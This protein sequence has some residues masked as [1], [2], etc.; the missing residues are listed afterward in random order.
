MIWQKN[1]KGLN[2]I[3]SYIKILWIYLARLYVIQF[4]LSLFHECFSPKKAYESINNLIK[5][6][7]LF[8]A[9]LRPMALQLVIND[10]ILGKGLLSEKKMRFTPRMHFLGLNLCSLWWFVHCSFIYSFWD[11]FLKSLWFSR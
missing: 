10:I 1:R 11:N 4:S 9:F 3:K 2:M 6:V 5:L 7:S 8:Y